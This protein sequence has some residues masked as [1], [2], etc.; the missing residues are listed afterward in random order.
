MIYRL[1]NLVGNSRMG[2]FQSNMN[3]NNFCRL[4]KG[5]CLFNVTPKINTY[6]DLTFVDYGS[7]ASIELSYK[8]NTV[9]TAMHIY[10]PILLKWDQSIHSL[11][12]FD[13]DIM[14]MKQEMYIE[15][16]LIRIPLLM[17]NKF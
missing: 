11:Q 7:L 16:F 5:M 2:K 13:Y 15:Q 4:L 14:L 9:N 12:A 8:S 17:I 3:E 1:R 10:N 6:V